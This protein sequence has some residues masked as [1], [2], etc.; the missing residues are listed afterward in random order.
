MIVEQTGT[1][2]LWQVL[3]DL[4]G[5]LAID[6]E[7]TGLNLYCGDVLRGVSLAWRDSVGGDLQTRYLSFTHPD[8][9]NLG[10]PAL[11][12][13]CRE[14]RNHQERGGLHLYHNACFDW[15]VLREAAGTDFVLPRQFWDTQTVSWLEDENLSH[16]LK[17]Q[18]AMWFGADAKAEQEALKALRRGRKVADIYKE[19]RQTDAFAGRGRGLAAQEAA[20]RL[21]AESKR[22]WDTFTA[23][24]IA[25]YAEQDT[26][27]TYR[28]W[29]RQTRQA[30]AKPTPNYVPAIERE[31]AVQQVAYRMMR[32]GIAVN[33][34]AV[35]RQRAGAEQE[36]ADIEAR[37]PDTN[38]GSNRE[39]ARLLYTDLGLPCIHRTATG[40]PS[41]ARE[42][43]EELEGHHPVVDDLL[44]YRRLQKALV[45]YYRPLERFIGEDGRIHPSFNTTGTK[46][47]RWSCS[48]P[49][50]QTI[51]RGDTLAGVRDVFVPT[52]GMELWE[53]DLASA[54]LRVMMGWAGEAGVVSALVEDRDLHSETAASI[55]GPEFTGL[56]R[57]LAKNLNYGFAYGIGPVKFS[58][59]MTKGTG[60]A[61]TI[62]DGW[63]WPGERKC[64]EC[65]AC[66]ASDILQGYRRS[67]PRLVRLMDGLTQTARDKGYLPLHVPGRFRRF[68][69]PGRQVSYYTALNALV[70]GGI[71][72]LMKDVVIR[73]EDAIGCLGQLVLQVH[74]SF[75]IEV[76]PGAGP[77]VHAILQGVLDDINPFPVPM[78]FDANEWSQHD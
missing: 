32:C 15:Q 51:P 5:P 40:A 4:D 58:G 70:Q 48:S 62:C 61:P 53:Y 17:D 28:L 24:D 16:R 68:R 47:G 37:W 2:R 35:L 76:E 26:A 63:L 72:E 22:D 25:A 64:G 10:Q 12:H 13:L 74:D 52:E 36:I 39:V 7:T 42:A 31:F 45:A 59:Y 19:L 57:R 46:T 1:P 56:Q 77:K 30:S 78:R 8:S 55:F 73:A 34:E 27:L 6:T 54:E 41:V 69:S 33:Q 50:L 44:R 49:N 11:K 23:E 66:Q 65:H 21:A 67:Y 29:E 18:G 20:R 3:S 75:V 9:P 38:L 60:V 43:L 71:G 14:L